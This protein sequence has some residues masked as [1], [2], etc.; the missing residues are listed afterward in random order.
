MKLNSE[1]TPEQ[2]IET[3]SKID[4]KNREEA[5]NMFDEH[6]NSPAHQN[7]H[8]STYFIH[9]NKMGCHNCGICWQWK[10]LTSK[11]E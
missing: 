3:Y 7:T 8:S 1:R 11:A 6:N 4:V 9:A 2:K 5:Q 10:E